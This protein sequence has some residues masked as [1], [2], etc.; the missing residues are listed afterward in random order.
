MKKRN[1][2]RRFRPGAAFAA[3][4]LVTT[5]V[6]AASPE[7]ATRLL[8]KADSIKSSNHP[9]FV[10]ILNSLS[11]RSARL[12]GSQNEYLSYLKGWNAAL[13]GENDSAL[14]T[15]KQLISQARDVTLQFRARSTLMNV[16]EVLRVYDAAYGELDRLV[17][18]LPRVADKGAREQAMM[19]AAQLYRA[20]G[21]TDLS[22][23]YSQLTMDENWADRGVCRGGQ[24]KMAALYESGRLLSVDGEVQSV[25]ASCEKRGE[26]GYA[27]EINSHIAKLYISQN[28]LDEAIALLKDHYDQVVHTQHIR[29]IADFDALLADAYHRKGLIALAQ[30]H[31]TDSLGAKSQFS[32]TAARALSV[33]YDI[34]K[35]QGDFKSALALHEKYVDADKGSL[36]E[37]S[38]RQLAYEKVIHENLADKLQVASLNEQKRVLQLQKELGAKAVE[39]SRLYITLLITI[40]AFVGLWAYKVKRSQLH[41]MSVSRLDGL[42]GISNRPHFLGEAESTLAHGRKTV[43][44]LCIILFDLDHFKSI[45]DRHGHAM[46]DYVLQQTVTRC[47]QHLGPDELFGRF[48][49][50]EFSILLPGVGVDQAWQRAEQ[51]RIGVAEIVASSGGAESKVSAS[52]GIA[53]SAA[54]GYELRQ[55]LAHADAALYQAKRAGRDRVVIYDSRVVLDGT[56]VAELEEQPEP[57]KP[58]QSSA[59]L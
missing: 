8:Q 23:R 36:D 53:A 3:L 5:C 4:L 39:N 25:I 47:R 15:L 30:Q 20:V 28:R 34:A 6:G 40:L 38:A 24:Q 35:E 21:Q 7:E 22:L 2:P 32:T 37:V 50:E 55:L 31:A 29:L 1:N 14:R 26:Y 10:E 57:D 11:A 42:T 13:A 17:Q 44:E 59:S 54:S 9:E 56:N 58:P 41:F 27:N 43:Q 16:E 48:G 51:L 12:S 46:G 45:N 19:N 33:L 49:G 18:L 52:F